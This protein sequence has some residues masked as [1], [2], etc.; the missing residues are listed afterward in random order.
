MRSKL[1]ST[2]AML[3]VAAAVFPVA[4][5]P[6]HTDTAAPA[7]VT[8]YAVP[9]ELLAPGH[10]SSSPLFAGMDMYEAACLPDGAGGIDCFREWGDVIING[11]QC[12]ASLFGIG[13]ILMAKRI[14][15]K[16]GEIADAV[17]RATATKRELLYKFLGILVG[18][19]W[20]T[21]G[22]VMDLM[23]CWDSQE[24]TSLP[25]AFRPEPLVREVNS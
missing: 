23:D 9:W 17:K 12:A 22:A 11:L 10:G 15:R 20:D 19:C 7:D 2:M 21:Y 3:A 18:E 5:Q 16:I 4:A 25:Q 14:A 6:A 8:A 24:T 13:R 1:I